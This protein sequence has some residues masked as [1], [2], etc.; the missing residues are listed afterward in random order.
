MSYKRKG[1]VIDFMYLGAFIFIVAVLFLVFGNMFKTSYEPIVKGANDTTQNIDNIEQ[2]AWF[3]DSFSTVLD[4]SF[5]FVVVLISV[6]AFI[7]AFFVKQHPI[8]YVFM[9]LFLFVA[10]FISMT[11]SNAYQEMAAGGFSSENVR[12]PITNWVMS[13]LPFIMFAICVL[14]GTVQFMKPGSAA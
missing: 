11:Y 3:G 5:L 7:S 12:Q 1:Q 13:Y 10:A 4:R 6:I 8:F 14:V 9:M 2:M